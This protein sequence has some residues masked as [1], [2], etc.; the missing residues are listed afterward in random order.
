METSSEQIRIRVQGLMNARMASLEL[1]ADRWIERTPPDFSRKRFLEFAENFYTHYPGFTGINWIDP[2]GIVRWVFPRESNERA[3]DNIVYDRLDLQVRDTFQKAGEHLKH[4]ATPCTEII[5]GGLGFHTFRPLVY[6]GRVQGYLN[7]VFQVKRVM[8]SCLA[9]NMLTHFWIR[10]YED[11]QL[12]YTNEKQSFSNAEKHTLHVLR[13]IR[14]PGKTWQLE[15]F[16]K[17]ALYPSRV[18]RHPGLLTFG[19]FISAILLLLLHFLNHRMQMYRQAR[20]HA[21]H[22]VSERKRAQEALKKNEKKLEV[23][24]KEL[25]DKNAEL[26]TFVFSV[27]HDLKTPIVTIEGFV[28]ALRE[29]FGNLISE[30]G[31]KYLNY[32]GDATRKMELLINDLLELS[33]IGRLTVKKTEF[34]LADLM[35]EVIAALQPQ[36][37]AKGVQVTVSQDLPLVYGE[38][39]RLVQVMENLLSNAIKYIGNEN[40]SPRIKVG[41]REQ[42]DQKVIFVKDNGIGIEKTYFE[43]I[44]QVF[45]RLPSAKKIGQ[46]TGIGL[47]IVKR[48]IEYHGGRVWLESEPGKGSTFF[49]ILKDKEA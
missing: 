31:E 29:D 19:M 28:G 6:T 2:G 9:K 45:Q 47:A 5:Q 24:L 12:I 38:K 7:G 40:P 8:E 16:P 30:E 44:F 22:E 4:V 39:K 17:V 21:L 25:A 42:D 20:D 41:V 33:R 11:D 43:K 10:I 46:G 3:I 14:F 48:I 26:E 13:E 1:L 32:I 49:F 34:P 23:L 15:L 18:V 35:E 36:I 37:E 27:S